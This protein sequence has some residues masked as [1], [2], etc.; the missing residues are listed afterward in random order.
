MYRY[1]VVRESRVKPAKFD[2]ADILALL[3]LLTCIWLVTEI[4]LVF[5]PYTSIFKF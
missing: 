5:T 1:S 3:G 2:I 4:A